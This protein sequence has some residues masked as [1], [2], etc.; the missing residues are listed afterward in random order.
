MPALST[1]VIEIDLEKIIGIMK[2]KNDLGFQLYPNP[3]SGIVQLMIPENVSPKSVQIC[4]VTGDLIQKFTT[5]DQTDFAF[6]SA[7]LE[8]GIYLIKTVHDT[9]ESVLKF[10]KR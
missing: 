2:E 1:G 10:V 8:S 5:I 9:G 6:D 7:H 4:S 3:G